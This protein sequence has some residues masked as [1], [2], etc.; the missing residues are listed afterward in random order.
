MLLF[1]QKNQTYNTHTHTNFL[2]KVIALCM[3]A[4]VSLCPVFKHQYFLLFFLLSSMIAFIYKNTIQMNCHKYHMYVEKR[5]E[6]ERTGRW[7]FLNFPHSLWPIG[8]LFLVPLASSFC[9]TFYVHARTRS[10]K[11]APTLEMTKNVVAENVMLISI[12]NL[13]L[14]IFSS[15]SALPC[16]VST[17]LSFHVTYSKSGFSLSSAHAQ[18]VRSECQTMWNQ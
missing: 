2:Y 7:F 5:R 1:E 11:N 17:S 4:S 12:F 6:R 3:C 18:N 10:E 15:S 9:C 8:A 14:N 16:T 13:R